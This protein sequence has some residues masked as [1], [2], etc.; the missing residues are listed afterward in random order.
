MVIG[1][2][3]SANGGFPEAID[4]A[5]AA[6]AQYNAAGGIDGH[7]ITI[8]SCNDQ[9]DAN[10]DAA[11]A[12]QAVTDKVAAV[13]TGYAS[14]GASIVP[15]LAN[16][17]IPYL[18]GEPGTDTEWNSPASYPFG[19]GTAGIYIAL[20]TRFYN[21]SCTKMATITGPIAAGESAAAAA[22]SG[23]EALGGKVV[24]QSVVPTATADYSPEVQ[25]AINAGAT[26]I[27]PIIPQSGNL[28]VIKSAKAA[29]PSMLLTGNGIDPAVLAQLGSLTHG[30]ISGQTTYGN[31]SAQVA[32]FV[33]A[34]HSYSPSAKVTR[35]S[36]NAY[37]GVQAAVQAAKGLTTVNGP[38]LTAALD[39]ATVT[40]T[41]YP[42]P[43]DFSKPA[44]VPGWSRCF[45]TNEVVLTF[46]GHQFAS[47]VIV[48]A[49]PGL[50][51]FRSGS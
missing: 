15:T 16:A 22:K 43:I 24:H 19:S 34:M 17:K 37:N 46:D 10:T 21:L 6:A 45:N 41:G 50:K 49:L 51:A 30:V 14:Y 7:Q 47:P 33:T 36:L 9:F 5:K 25:E 23:F 48:D 3:Q 31:S 13:V 1:L 4:G 35:F 2:F 12:Q 44:G 32:P 18:G 42:E 39:K 28:S 40:L 11:C 38:S 26:C 27:E 8:E 20:A 29:M